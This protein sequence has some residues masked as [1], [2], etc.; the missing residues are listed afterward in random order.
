MLV[1]TTITGAMPVTSTLNVAEA[2]F[3]EPSVAV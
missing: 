3:P 1:G 2:I